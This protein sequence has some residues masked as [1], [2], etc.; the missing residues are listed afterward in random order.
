MLEVCFNDS[1][2]GALR[3]AQNSEMKGKSI[4]G[5]SL[6][7]SEGDIQSKVFAE[8]SPRK[9]YIKSLISFNPYDD[10][11]ESDISKSLEKWWTGI[12][13]DFNKLQNT[14]ENLRIWLD[15][16][17][18]AMC[19]ILFVCNLLKDSE[20]QISVITLPKRITRDDKVIVE[21]RGWGEVEPKL[22]KTFLSE[23]KLL[24]KDEITAMSNE[25]QQLKVENAPIRVVKG[26]IVV[27]EEE[28]YY[29]DFIRKEIPNT[30]CKVAYII[31]NALSRQ[32]LLVGDVFIAKRI[33]HFIENGELVIVNQSTEGFYRTVVVKD[34]YI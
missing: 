25:W 3:H 9:E 16:T 20:R 28:N 6:G 34:K 31:G 24:T 30:P 14:D 4:L 23:E 18:D 33:L 22:F 12:K 26:D 10:F 19:G 1:V 21:Y 5:I 15:H 8:S 27:G 2:K 32:N 11:D 17:P 7:L 13:S 29:D